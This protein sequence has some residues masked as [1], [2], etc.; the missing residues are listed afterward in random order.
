MKKLASGRVSMVL[1]REDK[2]LMISSL[3]LATTKKGLYDHQFISLLETLDA[4]ATPNPKLLPSQLAIFRDLGYSYLNEESRN[5]FDA[6]M[7]TD[8]NKNKLS[9]P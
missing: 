8:L 1:S 7:P 5:Y 9:T 2:A 4:L 6:L 3:T